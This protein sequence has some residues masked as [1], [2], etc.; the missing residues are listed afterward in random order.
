MK[1]MLATC[2]YCH[3]RKHIITRMISVLGFF[4]IYFLHARLSTISTHSWTLKPSLKCVTYQEIS[5]TA[6]SGAHDINWQH[7]YNVQDI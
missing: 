1:T 2:S 6:Y 5:S 4:L 7:L 3:M